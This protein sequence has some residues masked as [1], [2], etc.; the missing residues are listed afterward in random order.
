MENVPLVSCDLAYA[1][2]LLMYERTLGLESEALALGP[3]LKY[4]GL[5]FLTFKMIVIA[6]VLIS[7]S[8]WK[9]QN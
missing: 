8:Y 6:T 2:S 1:G 4:E 3:S 5:E 7:R 9:G